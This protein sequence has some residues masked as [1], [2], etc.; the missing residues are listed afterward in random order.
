MDAGQLAV[1][2]GQRLVNSRQWTVSKFSYDIVLLMS[3]NVNF[4]QLLA[5]M[6]TVQWLHKPL[7]NGQWLVEPFANG[8]Y[9]VST[10]QFTDI[11]K[12]V[13]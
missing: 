5:A 8:H 12:T 4:I 1:D 13:S 10:V 6:L 7:S 11:N 2:S 9:T 3:L